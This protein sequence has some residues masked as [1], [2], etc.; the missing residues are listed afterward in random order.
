[1]ILTKLLIVL[2]SLL[3]HSWT[4]SVQSVVERELARIRA[5]GEPTTYEELSASYRLPATEANS[6]AEWDA[7]VQF[8]KTEAFQDSSK[9]MPLFDFDK[10]VPLPTE[11]WHEQENVK[12][13][14]ESHVEGE[15]LIRIAA[16]KSGSPRFP[17][18]FEDGLNTQLPHPQFLRSASKFI[19]LQFHLAIR[20]GNEAEVYM[21]ISQGFA[22]ARALENEPH[23]ISHVPRLGV[24]DQQAR[25]IVLALKSFDVPDEQLAKWQHQ[26]RECDGLKLLRLTLIGERVCGIQSFGDQKAFPVEEYPPA[27][28]G[29]WRPRHP[30]QFLC[31]LHTCRAAIDETKKG[32]PKASHLLWQMENWKFDTDV[33]AYEYFRRAYVRKA[34]WAFGTYAAGIGR[35]IAKLRATD[36][37]IAATRFRRKNGVWPQKLDSLTP[38][39]L[40]A[41]PLDPFRDQPLS[42]VREENRLTVYGF[43]FDQEDDGGNFDWSLKDDVVVLELQN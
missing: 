15:K 29:P 42:F 31:Y 12:R 43:G 21:A 2:A 38:K 39:F 6:S 3:Y 32:F 13:F 10:K 33:S 35:T 26:L 40:P 8:F 4:V 5:A 27:R 24:Y 9:E 28:Y 1:M 41:I 18:Q 25:L 36:T 34:F 19:E 37:L 17:I 20:D 23:M 22:I 11:E 14:I 16:E 30:I 7:V